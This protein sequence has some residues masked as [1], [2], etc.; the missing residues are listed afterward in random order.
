MGSGVCRFG[1][2]SPL[3]AWAPARGWA[4]ALPVR[5]VRLHG[6]PESHVSSAAFLC[7]LWCLPQNLRGV[8]PNG[9]GQW[10]QRGAWGRRARQADR[11]ACVFRAVWPRAGR[12]SPLIPASPPA[13]RATVRVWTWQAGSQNDLDLRCSW[14]SLEAAFPAEP[15][16]E[17]PSVAEDAGPSLLERT[18]QL[19]ASCW[20]PPTRRYTASLNGRPCF[21]GV[22]GRWAAPPEAQG[23]QACVQRVRLLCCWEAWH[24]RLVGMSAAFTLVPHGFSWWSVSLLV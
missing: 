21:L 11:Y 7:P 22:C 23:S 12:L 5:N 13:E 8:F 17:E 18:G 1:G 16:A 6:E 20:L 4:S 14:G 24:P 2:A 10:M 19:S 9:S 3:L 15:L